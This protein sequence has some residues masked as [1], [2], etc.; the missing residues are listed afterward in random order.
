MLGLIDRD[1]ALAAGKI[2]RGKIFKQRIGHHL[3]NIFDVFG[4]LLGQVAGIN[5]ENFLV[6]FAVKYQ[7]V[8]AVPLADEIFITRMA[9]SNSIKAA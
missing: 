3:V 1:R 8:V 6:R 5:Q 9:A 7:V 2:A 4:V